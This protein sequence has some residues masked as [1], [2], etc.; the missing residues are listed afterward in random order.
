MA[1]SKAPSAQFA[2]FVLLVVVKFRLHLHKLP[3]TSFYVYLFRWGITSWMV[4]KCR[5]VGKS[6]AM[7]YLWE[8]AINALFLWGHNCGTH[9]TR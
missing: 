3:Q 5:N 9:H 6:A 8:S 1:V 4:V 7:D 2:H